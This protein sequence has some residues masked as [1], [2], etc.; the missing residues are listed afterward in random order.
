MLEDYH[1]NNTV[2]DGVT[3]VD[4]KWCSILNVVRM[5]LSAHKHKIQK[6]GPLAPLSLWNSYSFCNVAMPV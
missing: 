2:Q 5:S 4:Q 6:R 3:G 1:K